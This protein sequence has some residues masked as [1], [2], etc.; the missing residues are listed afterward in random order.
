LR[1][2]GVWFFFDKEGRIYTI[3]LDAPF[4]GAVRGI[5]IGDTMAKITATLGQPLITLPNSLAS[6]AYIFR[7]NN[8]FRARFDLDENERIRTV[9]LLR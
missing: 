1:D 9:L 7:L 3:R 2:Y 8:D 6:K 4:N 5:R